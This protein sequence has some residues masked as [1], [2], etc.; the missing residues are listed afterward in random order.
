MPLRKHCFIRTWYLL[1]QDEDI[2]AGPESPGCTE[3]QPWQQGLGTGCKRSQGLEW[4]CSG[5]TVGSGAH[6]HGQQPSQLARGRSP[7]SSCLPASLWPIV[8]RTEPE[9]GQHRTWPPV[10]R[11]PDQHPRAGTIPGWVW[12]RITGDWPTWRQTTYAKAKRLESNCL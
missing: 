7:C 6:C 1:I 12:G 10:C 9:A 2:E 8:D 5:S 3:G 4:P 11:A